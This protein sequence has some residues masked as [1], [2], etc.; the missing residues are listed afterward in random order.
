MFSYLL[1]TDKCLVYPPDGMYMPLGYHLRKHY[2]KNALKGVLK[3]TLTEVVRIFVTS[4]VRII[5]FRPNDYMFQVC[6]R[7]L[8]NGLQYTYF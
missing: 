6:V 3:V 2:K 5:L 7:Y 8:Y 1:L 4:S